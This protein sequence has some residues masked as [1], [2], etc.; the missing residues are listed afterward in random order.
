MLHW[1][2]VYACLGTADR[3]AARRKTHRVRRAARARSEIA[4]YYVVIIKTDE[5]FVNAQQSK[6]QELL[7]EFI[8]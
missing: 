3:R 7:Q 6:R 8:V 1:S 5:G 2:I 4:I